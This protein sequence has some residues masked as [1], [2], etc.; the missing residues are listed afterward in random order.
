MIHRY[1]P[2]LGDIITF[3]VLAVFVD[4]NVLQ[5]GNKHIITFQCALLVQLVEAFVDGV[6]FCLQ[7]VFEEF[8]ISHFPAFLVDGYLYVES[9]IGSVVIFQT[10]IFWIEFTA[11]RNFRS[12]FTG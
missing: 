7:A 1:I 9:A 5:V 2:V 3:V 4:D 12:G 11:I 10:D 6:P 8:R